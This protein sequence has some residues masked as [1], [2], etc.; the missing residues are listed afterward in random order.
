MNDELLQTKLQVCNL[1]AQ[2]GQLQIQNASL[3]REK[4]QREAQDADKGHRE[5][6]IGIEAP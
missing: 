5:P 6:V 1:L 2:I 3:L 4:L